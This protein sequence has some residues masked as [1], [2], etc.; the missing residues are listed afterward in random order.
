MKKVFNNS[1]DY[2]IYSSAKKLHLYIIKYLSSKIP[3]VYANL[4][5]SLNDECN[6]LIKNIYASYLTD[7]SIRKKYINLSCVSISVINH[8][9]QMLDELDIIDNKTIISISKLLADVKIS[10]F[11]WRNKVI[12]EK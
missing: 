5:V 7:G 10:L 6:S 1:D 11:A 12:N 8:Y 3:K 9:F 2:H 4:R